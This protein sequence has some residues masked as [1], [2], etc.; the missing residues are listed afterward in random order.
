MV[1]RDSDSFFRSRRASRRAVLRAGAGVAGAAALGGFRATAGTAA[2]SSLQGGGSI[3][4]LSTQ[5]TPVEEA[6]AMRNEIL[7]DFQ[8]EVEFIAEEIGPFNDRVT[9]EAQT[10]KGTI[11]VLG[12]QHGDFSALAKQGVLTDLSDLATE[13]QDRG[14]IPQY[15]ELGRLGSQQLNYIPWMQATYIMAARRDALEFLPEGVDEAALQ[16]SL[17][18]DQLG[19]WAKNINDAQGQKFG[20]PAGEK[21]LLHRFLQGYGYPSFTGGVNTTFKS[22]DAVAMWSWLK[23]VWQY[24]NPQSVS[25][26]QMSEP[27]L[28]GE[29]SLAWD[30][31]ARLIDA[32][33]QNAEDFVTFPAPRGPKGLGFMPVVAG[34]AIP[35][36]APDPAAARSLIEYLTRPEVQATTLREVSFFPAIEAELP[37]DLP[38]GTQLEATAVQGTTGAEGAL[39]SLLPVGLGDQGGAYNKVFLDS[40][41]SIVLDGNDIQQVLDQQAANLQAVL[42]ATQASCWSPDP[43]SEGVCKVG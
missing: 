5:L 27:L 32:L 3:V 7:K 15:L 26:T 36:T 28:S 11:G 43:A 22:E 9:A 37:A 24:T 38:A 33:R 10:G 39:P 23:D 42:D 2:P 18:Y 25:Y 13:L 4:F 6:E 29:V 16:T 20:L 31:T 40:F 17:T 12:G 14:F 41:Q 21:G 30:H 34:L 35:K 19:M 1:P 8:G